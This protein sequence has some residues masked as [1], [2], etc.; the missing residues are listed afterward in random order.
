MLSR[1]AFIQLWAG[2]HVCIISSPLEEETVKSTCSLR[3]TT[4]PGQPI[5]VPSGRPASANRR[6]RSGMK[7]QLPPNDMVP[8][9]VKEKVLSV[10]GR[11]LELDCDNCAVWQNFCV[12]LLDFFTFVGCLKSP[13][14]IS[15][16]SQDVCRKLRRSTC[17][18]NV[19]EYRCLLASPWQWS[20]IFVHC[21]GV[22]RPHGR[23]TFQPWS[24]SSDDHWQG[25]EA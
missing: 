20:K 11:C 21:K 1:G 24:F 10:A 22:T 5:A 2:I 6:S 14:S 7:Q 15:D 12:L 4:I 3:D 13:L 18:R 9:E 17:D 25:G 23:S 19:V 16:V 8:R